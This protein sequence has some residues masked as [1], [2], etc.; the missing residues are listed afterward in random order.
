MK[1]DIRNRQD[2]QNLVD[3]FYAQVQVDS[4]IGEFFTQVAQVNWDT[5]LPQMYDFWE[6]ILFSRS[7]FSGN[8]MKIHK[9]LHQKKPLTMVHFAHWIEIFNATVDRLFSGENASRIKKNAAI[10]KENL[11]ARTI[12]PL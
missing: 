10:I 11:A 3:Q 12:M 6:S 7:I 1:T 9:E 5:H 2:I 4:T 8:P